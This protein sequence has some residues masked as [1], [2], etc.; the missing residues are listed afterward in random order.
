MRELAA[1]SPSQVALLLRATIQAHTPEQAG[2]RAKWLSERQ[3]EG[4]KTVQM[5]DA[6]ALT[7][8][9]SSWLCDWEGASFDGSPLCFDH[10]ALTPVVVNFVL[11]AHGDGINVYASGPNAALG[12]FIRLLKEPQAV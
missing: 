9:V 6:N 2:A 12:H 8:I 5:F 1:W 10:G 4:C 11:R 3:Q 7:F